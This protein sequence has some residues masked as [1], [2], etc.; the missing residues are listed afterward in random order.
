MTN[1]I[2]VSD[3]EQ[4]A[5][6]IATAGR[7]A[8]GA[9]ASVERDEVLATT[10]VMELLV[11]DGIER[12]AADGT[13]GQATTATLAGFAERATAATEEHKRIWSLRNRPGGLDES[14]A[15]FDRLLSGYV[16]KH[17]DPAGA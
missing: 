7:L 4:C 16:P 2:T 1:G 15:N 10:D 14:L 6:Q 13:L 5:A 9:P 8:V 12:V 11:D 3:L 17:H